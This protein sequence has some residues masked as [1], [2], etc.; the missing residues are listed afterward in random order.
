MAGKSLSFVYHFSATTNLSFAIFVL[1]AFCVSI[2]TS[3]DFSLSIINY[4]HL[5]SNVPSIKTQEELKLKHAMESIGFF[6]ITNHGINHEIMDKAW[7]DSIEFF[8]TNQSNKDSVPM[9]KEYIYGYQN[10]EILGRS[11]AQSAESNNNEYPQS[12]DEKETF[13]V[14]IGAPNTTRHKDVLWPIY[15]TNMN[16]SWTQYYRELEILIN[17]LLQSIAT[18][19]NLK[20]DFFEQYNDDHLTALRATNYPEIERKGN[21]QETIYRCSSHT[22]W[23]LL[24]LLRQDIVGGLQVENKTSNQWVHV[25][26]D[27]YDFVVNI[28]DL[29]QRWTNNKFKS[30][31]HRVVDYIKD[32]EN[33]D[34]IKITK[35]RQSMAFFYFVNGD[36]LIDVIPT[37]AKNETSL[38]QPV[39][40]YDYLESKHLSAQ[41]YDQDL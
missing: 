14:W 12:L 8:D 16:V 6:I 10:K 27:F 1:L 20:S 2:V 26:T 35:R 23:T 11:E 30:T 38:Y 17:G 40:V 28:G 18:V 25:I 4:G 36:T 41:T 7:N 32:N 39:I 19:L 13:N 34:I 9:S 22:D 21:E 3:F 37:C 15:P 33:D 31:R 24:T 29:M 5:K